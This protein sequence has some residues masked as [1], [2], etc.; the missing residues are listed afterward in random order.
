MPEPAA[1]QPLGNDFQ[2]MYRAE[3]KPVWSF[4]RRLGA[5]GRDLEDL[6]QEVFLTAYQRR[7]AYDP[8]Q[9]IRPWLLGIAYRRAADHRRL[10]YH[11]RET[12]AEAAPEVPDERQDHERS[13]L[14][15]EAK[16]LVYQALDELPL[17]KRALVA[18][19]DLEGESVPAIA[20]ALGVPLNTTYSR[21][22]LARDQFARA[23]AAAQERRRSHVSV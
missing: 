5:Q 3:L 23:F 12:E 20:Q 15:K 16:E 22:R 8:A 13:L 7:E 1:P 11:A 17:E 4:L 9:P 18:L 2:A 6:T 10:A 14:A 21:L 19:H